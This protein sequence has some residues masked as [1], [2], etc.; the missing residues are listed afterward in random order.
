[1]RV[2]TIEDDP[3]AQMMLKNILCKFA[4]VTESANGEEGLQTFCAALKDGNG[5]DL[6]CLDIGLPDVQGNDLLQML[7]KTET[8]KPTKPAVVLVM[9]ASHEIQ[10]IQKMITLGA[11]GYFV[12]PVNRVKLI[13]RLRELG[14]AVRAGSKT[15]A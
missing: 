5:F 13:V 6:V 15:T 11:D 1:M 9:T 2:L 8:E 14:F 10:V 12:K 3:T 4:D 7:R